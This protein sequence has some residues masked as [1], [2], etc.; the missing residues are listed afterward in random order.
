VTVNGSLAVVATLLSRN[1]VDGG[2]FTPARLCGIELVTQ[3]P[4]SG[5]LNLV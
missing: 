1:T 2:S 3:L 4:G 5:A